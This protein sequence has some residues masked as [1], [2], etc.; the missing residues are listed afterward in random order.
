M[1]GA[2]APL[3]EVRVTTRPGLLQI[4]FALNL[5]WGSG[6]RV[7]GSGFRAHGLWSKV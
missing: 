1:T 2:D 5:P 6:S 3:R 7:Q 4:A